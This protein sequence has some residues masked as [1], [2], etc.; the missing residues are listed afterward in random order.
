MDVLQQSIHS[1]RLSLNIYVQCDC[2]HVMHMY[3]YFTYA[4]KRGY[5]LYSCMHKSNEHVPM[6]PPARV[7]TNTKHMPFDIVKTIKH[8]ITKNSVT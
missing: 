3:T 8:T 5:S 1:N 4:E 2:T 6:R 7:N